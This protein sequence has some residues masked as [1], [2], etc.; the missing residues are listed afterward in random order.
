MTLDKSF[1]DQFPEVTLASDRGFNSLKS[2]PAVLNAAYPFL[3]DYKIGFSTKDTL[4]L[5][6]ANGWRQLTSEWVPKKD[7]DSF[8][9]AVKA[10]RFGIME[11]EDGSLWHKENCLMIMSRD[12]YNRRIAYRQ[13]IQEKNRAA[14][15]EAQEEAV[16]VDAG[17]MTK[18]SLKEWKVTMGGGIE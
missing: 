7:I 17:N 18:S 4:A 1:W 11:K 9:K 15:L 13:Q 12:F 3:R 5:A 6:N 16:K 8:N 2:I 10:G 14:I